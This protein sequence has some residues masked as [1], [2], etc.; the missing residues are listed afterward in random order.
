MEVMAMLVDWSD[1]ETFWLNVTNALLGLV[2]VV[3]LALVAGAA[4]VE[5]FGRL[6]ARL[7]SSAFDPH[8]LPAPGLGTT[9]ADGGEKTKDEESPF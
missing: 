2:T 5:I 7:F 6:K 4:A 9:M 8:V 1:P 3:A